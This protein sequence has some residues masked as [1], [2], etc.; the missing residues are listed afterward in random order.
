MGIFADVAIFLAPG[1]F[2]VEQESDN[3][4]LMSNYKFS[5]IVTSRKE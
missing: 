5:L 2:Y 1:D 3:A 4:A